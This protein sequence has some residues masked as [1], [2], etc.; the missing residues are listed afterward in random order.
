MLGLVISFCSAATFG[1]NQVVTRRGVLRASASYI[2]NISIFSGPFFFLAVTAITGDLFR[3]GSYPWQSYGLFA[4]SG[5]IHFAFGR[6]FGYRALLMIG[7]MRANLIT[8]MNAIVTVGLAMLVLKEVLTPLVAIGIVLSLSGPVLI[9]FKEEMADA[10]TMRSTP[11]GKHVNRET[12]FRGIFFGA[13][14]AVF[15]GSTPILIKMALDAGGSTMT[16]SLTAFS[17][18]SLVIAPSLLRSKTRQEIVCSGPECLKLALMSG[19]TTNLAQLF[20]F[21]AL[22]FTTAINVSLISRTIPVWTLI[23]AFAFNRKIDSFNRWVLIGNGLLLL[24]S[25]VIVADQFWSF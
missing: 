9:A 15:W 18:A 14:A 1:V 4:I 19:M 16:G 13:A 5:V 10:E 22:G 11:Q 12:L 8:S 24:G 7:T 20:R 17:A 21:L 3:L 23:M 2:A 25:F 6:T